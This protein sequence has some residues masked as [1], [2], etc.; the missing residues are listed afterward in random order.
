MIKIIQNFQIVKQVFVDN[1]TTFL[2]WLWETDSVRTAAQRFFY[3][4]DNVILR[5]DRS[6]VFILC[7]R[8]GGVGAGIVQFIDF[9]L[10]SLFFGQKAV[11]KEGRIEYS[12]VSVDTHFT[13]GFNIFRLKQ[14]IWLP[15][16]LFKNPVG[17]L[18][19][20]VALFIQKKRNLFHAG[21]FS[22]L[23]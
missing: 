16:F 13:D 17:N 22:L 14:N 23:F 4:I 10:P 15:V 3:D 1:A 8:N 2:L 5:N 18:P 6:M 21:D 20:N 11:K 9:Q 19:G 7:N 12:P